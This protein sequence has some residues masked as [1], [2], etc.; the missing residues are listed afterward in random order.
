MTQHELLLKLDRWA[1]SDEHDPAYTRALL[2]LAAAEIRRLSPPPPQP[3]VTAE[4]YRGF[5]L[6][7][8][9]AGL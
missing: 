2:R 1:V 7:E 6:N 3:R 5:C 8:P 4:E 9:E